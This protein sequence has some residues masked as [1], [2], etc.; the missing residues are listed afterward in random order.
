MCVCVCVCVCNLFGQ[1]AYI[2]LLTN[3]S[4]EVVFVSYMQRSK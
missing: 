1:S 2:V 3:H 4:I